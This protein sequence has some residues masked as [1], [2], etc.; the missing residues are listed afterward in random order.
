MSPKQVR[1]SAVEVA[2]DNVYESLSRVA[3]ML[4]PD[5]N[6]LTEIEASREDV[7]WKKVAGRLSRINVE[8][9]C[10]LEELLVSMLHLSM[11]SVER[12]KHNLLVLFEQLPTHI[13]NDI[14]GYVTESQLEWAQQWRGTFFYR[15][16]QH[17]TD[18]SLM[19]VVTA[20]VTA[21]TASLA[22]AFIGPMVSYTALA[23]QV[24]LAVA[25]TVRNMPRDPEVST[26]QLE[27]LVGGLLEE[28]ERV[29][30]AL[31]Y[32]TWL[33]PDGSPPHGW[34]PPDDWQPRFT[35]ASDLD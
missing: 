35:P 19:S 32:P 7:Y 22:S 13:Q 30:D 23:I 11:V 29:R 10:C 12:N 20:D 2:L 31:A 17:P 3:S 18:T 27:N 14:L 15:G 8:I 1:I 9:H 4:R 33:Y 16:P 24:S 5:W 25:D 26:D 21:Y 34:R 28:A 6:E